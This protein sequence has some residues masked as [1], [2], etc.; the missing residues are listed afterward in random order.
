[1]TRS[2]L[3]VVTALAGA[4]C[5]ASAEAAHITSVEPDMGPTAGNVSIT[6]RG[7]DFAPA[8]NS[9]TIGSRLCPVT[10]E[11]AD[12]I[13]CTL[14]EGTGA[15]SP[16][17]VVDGS[18]TASPP[19]PFAYSPPAITAVTAAT[20]PT[21]GGFPITIVGE[22]FGPAGG[23]TIWGLGGNA[24]LAPCIHDALTP[25]SRMVCTAPS[26]VGHDVPVEV[27]VDGQI[28]PPSSF[29]YDPPAITAI[30]PTRGPAAGGVI[31]TIRGDSFGNAATVLV[32]A[33]QCP[34]EAQT[35]DQIEC[36][37]PADGGAPPSVRVLVGGQASDAFAYSY[38]QVASKCDAGKIKAAAG[39]GKCL[40]TAEANAAKKGLEPTAAA[41]AK[42]DEKM[43]TACAKA[44]SSS[45][46]C[47]Q[48]GTCSA[49]AAG[50]GRKGWDGMIYGNSR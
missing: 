30:T 45:S 50:T 31:I 38:Q 42:C 35:H 2:L 47:S 9:V 12:E 10:G 27:M 7:L 15:S 20:A 5:I 19:Y 23:R 44:E 6:I 40:A 13:V 14:P 34:I 11:A 21:A 24:E 49:L 41:L 4:V 39:Y 26:G 18:G 16:I 48:P 1:M 33:S 17:S 43:A 22:N 25:H 8:G 29:S 3:A 37:L 36:E 46:D 28:S 32:G